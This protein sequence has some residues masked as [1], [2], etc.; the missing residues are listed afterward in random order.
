MCS[1]C[2]PLIA[3]SWPDNGLQGAGIAVAPVGRTTGVLPSN[4]TVHLD[5]AFASAINS[6]WPGSI[7]TAVTLPY[8]GALPAGVTSTHPAFPRAPA[9]SEVGLPTGSHAGKAPRGV[10]LIIHGGSWSATGAGAVQTM[11]PE[12]DRWRTRGWETV[13]L[14]YRPCGRSLGDVL[15]FYD[16]ARTWFGPNAAIAALG[17]SAGANLALLVV[18]GRAGVYG[19]ISQAGP[20]DLTTIQSARVQPRD[21]AAR[22]HAR[23][24][25]GAQPR[26]RGVRQ[27]EP[28][29]MQPGGPSASALNGARV[30][31]ASADD[32]IVPYQQTAD[33]A[34][35]LLV[36]NPAAYVDNVQLA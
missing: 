18:A 25:L 16:R 31:Q 35:P 33:L 29:L 28:G 23:S 11:R 8:S 20:T 26:R 36:A 5:G 27:G 15:W 13:N 34:G 9:Y 12:A 22:L 4:S 32:A 14:T 7:C 1:T 21:R 10:M 17:I 24:S 3:H 6:G 19:V 30:L 2:E